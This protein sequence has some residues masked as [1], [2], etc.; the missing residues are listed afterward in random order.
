MNR[1]ILILI[2]LNLLT[3]LKKNKI[4]ILHD[5]ISEGFIDYEKKIAVVSSKDIFG[6][7]IMQQNKKNYSSAG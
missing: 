4:S 5:E 6:N 3:T 2:I 1:I 7:Y